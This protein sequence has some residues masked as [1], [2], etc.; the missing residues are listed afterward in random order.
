ME[1]IMDYLVGSLQSSG[2]R[3]A[4]H[5]GKPAAAETARLRAPSGRQDEE[6]RDQP[7]RLQTKEKKM[8]SRYRLLASASVTLRNQSHGPRALAHLV[9]FYLFFA[10]Q[11]YVYILH[12]GPP[13]R[14]GP[15]PS[16]HWLYA[17]A[18]PGSTKVTIYAKF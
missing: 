10:G 14:L 6:I 18:G 7:S 15:G 9:V 13:S 3:T 16:P 1:W 8:S 11:Q 17:R 2:Y 12:H 4:T 5:S